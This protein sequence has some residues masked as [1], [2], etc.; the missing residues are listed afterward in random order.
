MKIV[1]IIARLN[2]GGP[3]R[4]VVWLTD[5][6]R[7]GEFETILVTGTVPEGEEDMGYFAAEHGIEPVF[8]PEMSRE[9]SPKDAIS[10]FKA[11][12]LF[13]R[14]KPDV[15]HTHTAKAGTVGRVAAVIY[16]WLFWRDVKVVH[17]FHGHV[18]HSYYGRLKTWVF[19]AIERILARIATDRIVVISDQQRDEIS[20]IFRVGRPDQFVVIPLGID[21]RTYDPPPAAREAF[22]D[23]IGASPDEILVGFVGR[24]TGI[25]NLP[26]FIE[27]AG[28]YLEKRTA[29]D[30]K[31]RFVIVGD[32]HERESLES[33]S[34]E[35]RTDGILNFVGHRDDPQVF[36][37]GLDIVALCSLNEGTPLSL[38]EAM[39]CG[40]PFVST[41]VGGVVDLAG[42]L[43][44]S[45]DDF[46]ICERG[47]TAASGDVNGFLNGLLR[48]AADEEL[49]NKLSK[50]GRQF[51]ESNY[52][53][54]RLVADIRELYRGFKQ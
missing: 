21:L 49:R 18:F 42:D 8:I 47:V 54:D 23:S 32:G 33:L 19:L 17:T 37:A 31:L 27:T 9:L 20:R 45:E 24:L 44:S 38:V 15:I 43:S 25:K 46:E 11:L 3:A 28:R 4:H 5:A 6:M 16:R 48:L 51:V 52:S 39:A 41:A 26:M 12:R 35:L 40:K 50:S 13:V 36:Y 22:R 30:P 10:L 14:E 7:D 29:S 2:V 53:R 1:R 34:R